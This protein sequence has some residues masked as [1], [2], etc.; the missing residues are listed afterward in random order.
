MKTV[1]WPCCMV[2][3]PRLVFTLVLDTLAVI[4]FGGHNTWPLCSVTENKLGPLSASYHSVII[5]SAGVSSK[6]AVFQV[7]NILIP[8]HKVARWLNM[9]AVH[10]AYGGVCKGKNS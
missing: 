3:Y 7:P 4:K 8:N 9:G 1:L 2:Q 5:N 6:G 10:G